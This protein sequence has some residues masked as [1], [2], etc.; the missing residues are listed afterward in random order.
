MTHSA[1]NMAPVPW[2]P[3]ERAWM[4]DDINLPKCQ[5]AFIEAAA[6]T[7]TPLVGVAF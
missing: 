2:P 7:G 6:T 5:E 3:W 4:E 1:E